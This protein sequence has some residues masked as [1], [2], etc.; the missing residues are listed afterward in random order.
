MLHYFYLGSYRVL[1][2]QEGLKSA[3]DVI[4]NEKYPLIIL[5]VPFVIF[6]LIQ[7]Y[8]DVVNIVLF[9]SITVHSVPEKFISSAFC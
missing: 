7:T 9:S 4:W 8:T 5:L 1:F 2:L 3:C 6:C